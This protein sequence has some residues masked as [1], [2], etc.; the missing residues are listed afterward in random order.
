MTPTVQ[1]C[2]TYPLEDAPG[3]LSH[4]F[5]QNETDGTV[6]IGITKTSGD[7]YHCAYVEKELFLKHIDKF[8]EILNG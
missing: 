3:F 7:I 8:R 5:I 6:A 1:M 4:A 2:L